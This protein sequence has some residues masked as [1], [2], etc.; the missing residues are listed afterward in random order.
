MAPNHF[1]D[2]CCRR[3][4]LTRRVGMPLMRNCSLIIRSDGIC[5]RN[6]H[7]GM[8]IS[9][10]CHQ[11]SSPCVSPLTFRSGS[12]LN[13]SNLVDTCHTNG[14]IIIGTPNA[15]ITSSGDLCPFIPSVVRFC[16]NR[17][18]VLP[19]VRACRY[20]GPSRLDC[21]LSGLSGLIIGRAR[22][23]NNCNVLVKPAS[24]GRRVG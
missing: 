7:N 3:T 12:V 9:V 14:I 16:L 19:G 18:P 24:A 23:S 5:V 20:H 17:G 22:N 1:G 10:V 4:F 13:I 11:V 15:N 6:V 21:M 2:T 8:R